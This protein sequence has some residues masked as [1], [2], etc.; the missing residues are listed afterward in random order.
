MSATMFGTTGGP[1]LALFSLGM[2]TTRANA[3]GVWIGFVIGFWTV[4]WI[5]IGALVHPPRYPKQPMSITGCPSNVTN[6]NMSSLNPARLYVLLC[7][8][9]SLKLKDGSVIVNVLNKFYL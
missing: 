5:S 8:N 4:M 6:F 2:L 9:F 7:I 1:T 3:K